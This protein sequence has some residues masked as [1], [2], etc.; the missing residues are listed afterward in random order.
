M[1]SL[2][3]RVLSGRGLQ[4]VR[5]AAL[6]LVVD[7]M[8]ADQMAF[9]VMM[10]AHEMHV[11]AAT[12]ADFHDARRRRNINATQRERMRRQRRRGRQSNCPDEQQCR[13]AQ[14]DPPW[15]TDGSG[16]TTG[17]RDAVYR[18]NVVKGW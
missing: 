16:T 18:R 5:D 4:R 7:A 8:T 17:P 2:T 3:Y 12:P 11:L 6:A 10:G 9:L 1:L 14:I 13:N 15:E